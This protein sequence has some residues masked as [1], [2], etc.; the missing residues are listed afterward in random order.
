[1]VGLRRCLAALL[2]VL[3]ALGDGASGDGE[4]D[5]GE[6]ANCHPGVGQRVQMEFTSSVV[7]HGKWSLVRSPV[8]TREGRE[9]SAGPV[10]SHKRDLV[11]FLSCFLY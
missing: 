2:P 1:M 10:L 6:R 4:S 5:H 3:T 8:V 7:E 11:H 9:N